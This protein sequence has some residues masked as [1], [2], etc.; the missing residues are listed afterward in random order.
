MIDIIIFRWCH[1]VAKMGM[2]RILASICIPVIRI[3]R[4][5]DTNFPEVW[6][7]EWSGLA[8]F[9]DNPGYAHLTVF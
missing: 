4:T 9:D 7:P 6:D 1:S 2:G 8:G 5:S 3:A